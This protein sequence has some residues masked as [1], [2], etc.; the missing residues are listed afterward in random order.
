MNRLRTRKHNIDFMFLMILF[1]IFTFSAV[2]VLL[3]AVNSYRSVVNA[4]EQATD[5]RAAMAYLREVIHKND[6]ASTISIGSFD[7]IDCVVIA[8]ESGEYSRYIY[9]YDGY[10]MEL[11]AK[12]D[13][14]ATPEFGDKILEVNSFEVEWLDEDKD[15]IEATIEDTSGNTHVVDIA[16]KSGGVN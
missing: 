2:S 11:M 16:V 3:M 4:N 8:D 5:A 9:A 12:D 13:S 6:V 10:L 15:A 14:G 1:L 7:G